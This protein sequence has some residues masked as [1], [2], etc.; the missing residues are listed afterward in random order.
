VDQRGYQIA[1]QGVFVQ[2]QQSE[3]VV[4]WPADLATAPLLSVTT[5][6]NED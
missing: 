5:S 6:A 1:N 3:K 4:V 2:W